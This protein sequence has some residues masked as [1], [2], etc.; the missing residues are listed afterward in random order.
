MP[1]EAPLPPAVAAAAQPLLHLPRLLT[2]HLLQSASVLRWPRRH[3]C[4]LL[5]LLLLLLLSPCCACLAC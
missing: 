2:Q 1:D 5:L 4:R 3:H